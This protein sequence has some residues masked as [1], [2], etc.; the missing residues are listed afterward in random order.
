[1]H[2]SFIKLLEM[3]TAVFIAYNLTWLSIHSL[4]NWN[5]FENGVLLKPYD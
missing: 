3:P 1:M 4:L 5:I 2:I